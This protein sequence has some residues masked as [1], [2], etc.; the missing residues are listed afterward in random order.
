MSSL[1]KEL[2]P[3]L[4]IAV[5]LGIIGVISIWVQAPLLIP[6][7]GSAIFL[8]TL[9]PEEPSARPWNT[10]VGQLVGAAAGF[11]GVFVAAAASTPHFMADDRLTFARVA[12]A[13]I[14]VLLSAA[15][16]RVL[17]ATSAAG[18]ATALVVALGAETATEAGAIR[19]FFGILLVTAIGEAARQLILRSR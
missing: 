2:L 7:L 13:V 11:I 12:A 8:Q 1:S 10:G 18:G 4:L 9:T 16:Q 6:S 14:A 3:P 17:K 15:G 19:L 5:V